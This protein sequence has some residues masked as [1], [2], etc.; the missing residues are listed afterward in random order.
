MEKRQRPLVD[1]VPGLELAQLHPRPAFIPGRQGIFHR[2]RRNPARIPAVFGD[3]LAANDRRLRAGSVIFCKEPLVRRPEQPGPKASNRLVGLKRN[4]AREPAA[5]HRVVPLEG[6]GVINDVAHADILQH[7]NRGILAVEFML[8]QIALLLD[9]FDLVPVEAVEKIR[10]APDSHPVQL[11]RFIAGV[12]I[13][14]DL[15]AVLHAGITANLFYPV[16]EGRAFGNVDFRFN[17]QP[18]FVFTGRHRGVLQLALEENGFH[19]ACGW[20]HGDLGIGN[21]GVRRPRREGEKKCQPKNH[22]PAKIDW[23]SDPHG[24]CGEHDK[25][26][27]ADKPIFK[28]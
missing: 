6:I 21:V 17:Q 10:A 28:G 25:I 15:R 7:Q 13:Q 24:P 18:A 9:G 12:K 27:A 22:P 1:F 5:K 14:G 2:Q 3:L 19:P 23:G 16:F 26:T 8:F 11:Q 4:G 20:R